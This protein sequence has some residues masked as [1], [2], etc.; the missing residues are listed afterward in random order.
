MVNAIQINNTVYNWNNVRDI[1]VKTDSDYNFHNDI[2]FILK[3]SIS[4]NCDY[5]D[6]ITA[7]IGQ[8]KKKTP[9]DKCED[10]CRELS[11]YI[12]ECIESENVKCLKLKDIKEK[13]AELAIEIIERK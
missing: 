10:I 1:S 11:N 4:T 5:I 3:I 2:T 6:Y 9:L 12:I 13:F 7:N 8:L